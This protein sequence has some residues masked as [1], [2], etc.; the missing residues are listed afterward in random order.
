MTQYRLLIAALLAAFALTACGEKAAEAPKADA[1]Q[2][3][4]AAE[5]AAPAAEQAAPAAPAEQAAPA[6]DQAAPK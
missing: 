4:P 5:Q 2:A 3:A 1:A 6:A